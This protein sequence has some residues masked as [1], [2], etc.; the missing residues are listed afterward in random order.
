MSSGTAPSLIRS[1]STTKSMRCPAKCSIHL[2]SCSDGVRHGA[3]RS[4]P[5]PI[6]AQ[7]EQ[8]RNERARRGGRP[9]LSAAA[10]RLVSRHLPNSAVGLSLPPRRSEN[11]IQRDQATG[12][13][14]ECRTDSAAE[15][16]DSA[17]HRSPPAPAVPPQARATAEPAQS[18]IR[19]NAVSVCRGRAGP[20][21][22]VPPSCADRRVR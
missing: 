21:R 5:R 16:A 13:A 19:R 22:P 2:E 8:R 17:R 10:V 1:P 14:H 18:R 20:G 4:R 11:L 12:T 6:C 7:A 9:A 15:G 3:V